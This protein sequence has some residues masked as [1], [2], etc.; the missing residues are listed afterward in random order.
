MISAQGFQVY[1]YSPLMFWQFCGVFFVPMLFV[2]RL[3]VVLTRPWVD[4]CPIDNYSD[5]GSKYKL[6]FS[7]ANSIKSALQCLFSNFLVHFK[8]K[9]KR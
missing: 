4:I 8:L 7:T 1:I 6:I 2:S 3:L 9:E 5:C